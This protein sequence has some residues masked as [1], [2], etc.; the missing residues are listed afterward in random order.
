MAK[1][2]TGT[3]KS[4]DDGHTY[5]IEIHDR[6]YTGV[7]SELAIQAPV[8]Y[9]YG[10]KQREIRTRVIPTTANLSVLLQS[11]TDEQLAIDM[12]LSDEGRF[13]LHVYDNGQIE[14]IGM[15]MVDQST[16][17]NITYPKSFLLSATDGLSLLKDKPYFAAQGQ[18]YINQDVSGKFRLGLTDDLEFTGGNVNDIDF[19]TDE[20]DIGDFVTSAQYSNIGTFD[21]VC[22]MSVIVDGFAS[23]NDNS[24]SVR[25]WKNNEPIA[26]VISTVE[27]GTKK[28]LTF[29]IKER[30]RLIEDDVLFIQFTVL[31][32]G[33]ISV[34]VEK[35]S[36]FENV[37]PSAASIIN[38]YGSLIDHLGNLLKQ[39]PTY[40]EYAD[41]PF[42]SV[43]LPYT[44]SSQGATDSEAYIGIPYNAFTKNIGSQPVET[45]SALKSLEQI[46]A[47]A[48]AQ[49]IY[50]GGQYHL[51]TNTG[52]PQKN[53]YDKSITKTGSSSGLFAELPMQC[54]FTSSYS[55]LPPYGK[56]AATF[57]RIRTKNIISEAAAFFP[58]ED[59]N[60]LYSKPVEWI[61]QILYFALALRIRGL[62]PGSPDTDIMRGPHRHIF[63]L[64]LKYGSK[65]IN[66]FNTI[67]GGPVDEVHYSSPEENDFILAS[68]YSE[69]YQEKPFQIYD[70]E[71]NFTLP[72][73]TY[74]GDF[75]VSIKYEH[76][77]YLDGDTKK[78]QQ[79]IGLRWDV[80]K[81]SLSSFDDSN[82]KEDELFFK[83][84]IVSEAI[85]GNNSFAHEFKLIASDLWLE[86][87]DPGAIKVWSGGEWVKGDLWDGKALQ[88]RIV[89]QSAVQQDKPVEL[90]NG[91]FCADNLLFG[92]AVYDNKE[93]ILLDGRFNTRSRELSGQ[94]YA[95]SSNDLYAAV[96]LKTYVKGAESDHSNSINSLQVNENTNNSLSAG[97]GLEFFEEF[98]NQTADHIIVSIKELPDPAELDSYAI[99]R[100]IK[101]FLNGVKMRFVDA[102]TQYNQYG[103]DLSTDNRI[104]FSEA[105]EDTDVVELYIKL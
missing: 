43:N 105:L 3:Y 35:G 13:F 70:F 82:S 54:L 100:S 77:L 8:V 76:T 75:E 91:T 1:R 58:N 104:V 83:E 22:H 29:D 56:I 67:D 66:I 103:I 49:L 41:G 99:R 11:S 57:D 79:L 72:P 96:E 92:H 59:V 24:V 61:E 50:R 14:F 42:L 90:F 69:P 62:H 98:E 9:R 47:I 48:N 46:A 44:E 85:K 101:L 15:I 40:D 5:T 39:L 17:Q 20:V 64:T 93:M 27:A 73:I 97:P 68:I 16:L 2:Y 6:L 53:D 28:R 12:I 25:L 33:T 60:F 18:S 87:S 23:N 51:I 10:G 78:F 81:M 63:T 31:S 38:V 55:F 89:E 74:T 65:K 26:Y 37:L 30:V 71:V 102:P 32:Q 95:R 86:D 45:I 19:W 84:S 94:W 88:E 7:S 36:Y 4:Y 52:I 80:I 21:F 34:K